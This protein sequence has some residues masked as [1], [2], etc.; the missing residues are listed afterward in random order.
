MLKHLYLGS[1]LFLI[2]STVNAQELN[3]DR[4]T[5]LK[6]DVSVLASDEFKGREAGT[7]S[8]ILARD[9][10]AKRFKEIGFEPYFGGKEYYE[11]FE[12]YGSI[13]YS[14]GLLLQV[15]GKKLKPDDDFYP[16]ANSSSGELKEIEIVDVSFGIVSP[17]QTYDD[18]AG[19]TNLKGK[20]FLLEISV[21]G[22]SANIAKFGEE[23]DIDIKIQ[24]AIKHGASAVIFHNS[25]STFDNPRNFISNNR[26]ESTIPV[27]FV[28]SNNLLNNWGGK[29]ANINVKME[30]TKLKAY[31]VAGYKDNGSRKTLV[32]GAHYDHLG[33]GGETSRYTKGKA[34]HNGADDNAS[35]VA[36]ILDLGKIL[37]NKKLNY[38][39]IIIAFS[40]EEKGLYGSNHFVKNHANNKEMMAMLNFDMVGRM[41]NDTKSLSLLGTGSCMEWD[42]LIGSTEKGK[43][44]ITKIKSGIGG[45]DQMP[46]YLDSI[47]V[48]FFFTGI[49]ADYHMP[50]DDMDKINFEGMLEIIDFATQLST[51]LNIYNELKY[52]KTTNESQGNRGHRGGISLGL[53]P[54]YDD[55]VV[56]LKVEDV[57][58]GK[59]AK[60]GGVLRND[61]ITKVEAM[62]I[63]NIG[64][65]MVALK[66][67]KKGQVVNIMVLR[68]GKE[69]ALKLQL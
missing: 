46:F 42:T 33:F 52:V 4:I 20:I 26:S 13:N 63:K 62:E 54:G 39:I 49:H 7:S 37:F 30:K 16:M 40:A 43:L 51:N 14:K 22:G 59:P 58:D 69:I 64:D 56:G 25:D 35:G 53:V 48:L 44:N 2:I 27:I 57:I 5:S 15:D 61:V 10:L 3:S 6:Q 21:P 24:N 31:N 23:A 8:E 65:Y 11:S 36:A 66:T 38:N 50:T 45:S 60:N 18:Y 67:L 9:F 47:P 12:F 32:I 29:T 17:S 34:I 55:S 68:D 19:K 41:N 28:K 1:I